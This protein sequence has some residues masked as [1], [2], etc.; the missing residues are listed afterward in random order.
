MKKKIICFDLDNTLC[1]TEKNYYRKS[2]P[3]RKKILL[4]N[5]LY[6]RGFIIKIFTARFMGRSKENTILAKKKGYK[7]TK[8]Q[9]DKWNLKYHYLIFGKPSYDLFIDDKNLGFQ[10]N[11]DKKILNI[12]K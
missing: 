2:K 8:K 4:V 12:L 6:D 9:L 5:N 7:F 3:I 1:K 10:K 11:W